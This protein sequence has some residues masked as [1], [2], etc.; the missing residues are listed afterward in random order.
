M[1]IYLINEEN[2]LDADSLEQNK[3]LQDLLKMAAKYNIKLLILLTH[4]DTYC[5]K[6]KKE[7]ED[8]KETGKNDINENKFNALNYINNV[9]GKDNSNLKFDEKD[10]IHIA[11]VEPKQYS[12]EELIKKFSKKLR[13]K[14][15]KADEEKKKEILEDFKD[16]I[17][18]NENEVL[19]FFKEENMDIL[20]PKELVD[21][22]K[23]YLPNQ[24]HNALN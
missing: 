5:E 22:M 19:Y 14:Y 13:E 12:N 4:S 6:L 23:E 8:W 21:K 20:D 1:I 7:D 18:S 15:D 24:Y 17:E 2:K 9:Y 16:T 3:Y 10:I 11:L